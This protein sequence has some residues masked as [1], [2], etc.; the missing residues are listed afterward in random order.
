MNQLVQWDRMG[1]LEF[2]LTKK[3]QG[4]KLRTISIIRNE[5]SHIL[6]PEVPCTCGINTQMGSLAENGV[7]QTT[8]GIYSQEQ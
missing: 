7:K 2:F 5:T 1:T 3:L 6:S 4:L 8:N